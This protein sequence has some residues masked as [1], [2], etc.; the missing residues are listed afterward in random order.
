MMAGG[1]ALALAAPSS[2]GLVALF[3]VASLA[4]VAFALGEVTMSHPTAHAALAARNMTHGPWSAHFWGGTALAVVG[5][6]L[7]ASAFVLPGVAAGLV[8]LFLFEHAYVQ[9]G[10]SV[11]LA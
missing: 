3:V 11:P 2:T 4:H 7:A 5:V 8:G 10:Q 9:A 6:L 1:G